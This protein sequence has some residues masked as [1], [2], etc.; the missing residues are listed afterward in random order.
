M[1]LYKHLYILPLLYIFTACSTTVP[2]ISE[3]RINTNLTTKE[4][5]Q[6]GCKDNSL[7]IAQAFSSSNLMTQS[8][9]Y[10]E[11]DFKQYTFRESQWAE[12]PNRAI[13]SEF[14]AYIKNSNLFKNVQI[15]KSR[16]KNGLLLET[17]IVDF[18]QYFSADEKSSY[19][20]V[21]IVLTLIDT[22]SNSVLATQSFSS[23]VEAKELSA[24]GGVVA[25][26]AALKSVVIEG[27]EWL[28]GV[29][30]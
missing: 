25:L 3:Y 21:S 18:M 28:A 19:S 20:N 15:S 8:M 17:N 16:S 7:K 29:C 13:T 4:F 5:T 27:G 2:A 26:N 10:G 9:R 14:L 30:K 1:K 11:G 24:E 22:K 12:S 23:R 6:H